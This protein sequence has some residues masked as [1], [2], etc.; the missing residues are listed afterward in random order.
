[1]R[2]TRDYVPAL[3]VVATVALALIGAA[4]LGSRVLPLDQIWMTTIIGMV[5]L[6]VAYGFALVG[7]GGIP[8]GVW[9]KRERG[10]FLVGSL[11]FLAGLLPQAYLPDWHI[12]L[13]A[14]AFAGVYAQALTQFSILSRN[15]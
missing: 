5:V 8:K 11:L 6:V 2:V 3:V 13:Y 4:A 12:P 1:M 10:C 15:G 7:N 9:T 14:L